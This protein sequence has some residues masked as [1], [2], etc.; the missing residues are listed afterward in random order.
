MRHRVFDS[1]YQSEGCT[2]VAVTSHSALRRDQ[3]ILGSHDWPHTRL[4]AYG[5]SICFSH[6][7]DSDFAVACLRISSFGRPVELHRHIKSNCCGSSGSWR[8]TIIRSEQTIFN[9]GNYQFWFAPRRFG[10]YLKCNIIERIS[11][12]FYSKTGLACV[13][14]RTIVEPQ[15]ERVKQQIPLVNKAL[16][17]HPL[18][19]A[20]VL[21]PQKHSCHQGQSSAERGSQAATAS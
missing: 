13:L 17:T 16:D 7:L 12:Q 11:G 18:A 10:N 1:S 9:R 2:L 4:S 14:V 5:R 8:P 15:D 6:F 20:E 21:G 19:F 3:V